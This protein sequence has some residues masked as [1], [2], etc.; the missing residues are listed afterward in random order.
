MG[1]IRVLLMAVIFVDFISGEFFH[2]CF[3]GELR[4]VERV[5]VGDVS[6]MGSCHRVIFLISFSGKL[7]M[8][9]R[10]LKVVSGFQM[11]VVGFVVEFVVVFGS[12]HFRMICGWLF[13]LFPTSFTR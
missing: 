2:G 7:M 9:G 10:Q 5:S 13:F 4:A 6:L 1:V 3:F 11:S 8:F 12:G